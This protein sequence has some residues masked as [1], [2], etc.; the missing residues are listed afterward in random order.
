MTPLEL[1]GPTEIDPLIAGLRRDF[2]LTLIDLPSVWTAWTN[3]VLQLAD[4]IVLVTNLSVAHIHLVRR[5]LAAI[6]AQGLGD[7]PLTLVCNALAPDQTASL[8][9]KAGERALGR[10]FD[11]VIPEDRKVMNDALNQGLEIASIKRGTK[12]EKAIALL[13]D[14]IVETQA[15]VAARRS[16]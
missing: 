12:L 13:A 2:G 15:V 4:R 1:L 5:Q 14:R 9:L 16:S 11:V 7:R 6:E 3:R 8:S 10:P